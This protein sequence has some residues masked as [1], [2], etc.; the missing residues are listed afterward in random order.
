ML[1][2][3]ESMN[4]RKLNHVLMHISAVTTLVNCPEK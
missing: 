3:F 1:S 2:I 4:Y